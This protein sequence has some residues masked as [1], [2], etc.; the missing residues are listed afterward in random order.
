MA[1][2]FMEMYLCVECWH[3]DYQFHIT[4]AIY[5]LLKILP[6]FVFFICLLMHYNDG[7]NNIID[8]NSNPSCFMLFNVEGV[9]YYNSYFREKL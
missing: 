2:Y 1:N 7:N 3:S 6:Q 9:L 8:N 4:K 5:T